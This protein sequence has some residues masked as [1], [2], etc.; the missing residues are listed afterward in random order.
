MKQHILFAFLIL[1]LLL[2]S[3][4]N[5]CEKRDAISI[6]KTLS[7]VQK[8]LERYPNAE[9][10]AALWDNETVVT[11][12]NK[13]KANCGEQMRVKSYWRVEV[14]E[15]SNSLIVWL[16]ELT[17]EPICIVKPRTEI[18]EEPVEEAPSEEKEE[19]PEEE[20]EPIENKTCEDYGY[21]SESSPVVTCAVHTINGMKCY[22]CP[23]EI[24]DNESTKEPICE[25]IICGDV[26]ITPICISNLDCDDNLISTKDICINPNSCSASCSHTKITECIHDD[27]Y[28]TPSC[29][30]D[31]DN[32]CSLV[33][34]LP[35]S[36]SSST[37]MAADDLYLYLAYRDGTIK[38]WSKSDGS[39]IKVVAFTNETYEEG[40]Y[41]I[42]VDNDYI[43][44]KAHSPY[45][46]FH[47]DV[48]ILIWSKSNYSLVETI[49]TGHQRY[50]DF[51]S[52][53][54][55]DDYI[56]SVGTGEYAPYS[57]KMWDKKN[58]N[59]TRSI[60][61]TFAPHI[62]TVYGNYIYAME[63][64]TLKIIDKMSGDLISEKSIYVP[65][66]RNYANNPRWISADERYVY[67]SYYKDSIPY[68]AVVDKISGNVYK[69]DKGLSGE[70]TSIFLSDE[71]YIY[72]NRNA[73]IWWK[74]NL[75]LYKHIGPLDC[76]G[77]IAIDTNYLYTG[78]GGIY[79]TKI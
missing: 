72:N 48:P 55:D 51:P 50:Y 11:N 23:N 3:G 32:D 60:N 5:G 26:C 16:D 68:D 64:G 33:K 40:L 39:L 43:Y 22:D 52:V 77:M 67:V 10:K 24:I 27:G 9:I 42:T 73:N 7:E 66:Y 63:Y 19:I 38:I 62:A 29:L 56:Y 12:I 15:N 4:F 34:K 46:P 53:I 76:G 47:S 25:G 20:K 75:S 1:G 69:L 70:G 2:V 49:Y 74:S 45:R 78:C 58:R 36:S 18:P 61:L 44:A 31:E 54:V 14:I 79:S 17:L 28:C 65:D 41:H 30:Y 6:V 59:F 21:S 57:L 8:F 35:I 37:S 71:Y 13:I